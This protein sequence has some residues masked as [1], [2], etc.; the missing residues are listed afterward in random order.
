MQVHADYTQEETN[1]SPCNTN[2]WYAYID[3]V[4]SYKYLGLLISS[5][6]LWS[7]H[8]ESIC[9]KARKI[10]GLL[11]RKFSHDTEP[12][13]LLQLYLSLVRPH[14]E[15]GS[16]VWDPHL[17]KDINQLEGVQKFGLRICAKQWDLSYNELLSNFGLPTL[18]DRRL[19]LKL[20]TMFK[21]IHDLLV[22]PPVF[23]HCSTR[24]NVNSNTFIQPFAHT[25]SFLYSFV[26][27][28]IS[29]WNSLPNSGLLMLIL[30]LPFKSQLNTYL[31]NS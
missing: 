10:L 16:Q 26:P 28:S 12:Y 20:A 2:Q 23:V 25:N 14:F 24:V 31:Y 19:Y 3:M 27:H 30:S 21:I 5:D 8:I 11:Y 29:L 6:L 18:N 22:F 1:V 7:H 13:A 17:Q 9:G 4:D 15:Y